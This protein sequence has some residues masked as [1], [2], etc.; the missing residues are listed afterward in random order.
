MSDGFLIETDGLRFAYREKKDKQ[1]LDGI[2]LRVKSN[3]YLLISGTSG[4]G[5]STL[6]R[7]FNGLIPHFTGG[8]LQGDVRVSGITTAHRTTEQLF[9]QVG[10]VFQN[11][12]AQ[13]FNR[14][15]ER[16]M[17]F[18]LESIGLPQQKMKNRIHATAEKI[19]ISTLMHRSPAELS[20]GEQQL[21]AI[22]AIMVLEPKLI[23]L[24]EPYSSLDPAHVGKV[25]N[26]LKKIHRQG[27]GIIICEHRLPY[28]VPDICRMLVLHDQKIVLDGSPQDVLKNH[29][30]QFGLELPLAARMGKH[31]KKDPLPLDIPALQKIDSLDTIPLDDFK[32]LRLPP[33][34]NKAEVVLEAENISFVRNKLHFLKDVG[35]T[36]R[37]GE[38][39]AVVGGNGAG[40]TTLLKHLI[41]LYRPTRGKVKVLG[42]DAGKL[43]VSELARYVGMAFQN[44]DNQFFRQTA[45]DEITTGAQTLGCYDEAWIK[46]LVQ[47]FNLEQLLRRAPYRLSGGE[48]KRVAFASAL[49]ANPAIL[50]LDEPT[51]GQDWFF[52]KTLGNLLNEMRERGLAIILVTHD[53]AFAEQYAHQWLVLAGGRVAAYDEPW[54]VMA[55]KSIL[56][57]AN[58][59]PTDAF[60]LFG[61]KY[62]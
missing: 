27:I 51:S 54:K 46:K 4:S 62:A 11:P 32:P 9:D 40:K 3:D 28:T 8:V 6:C 23:V 36:L 44:P 18:G 42:R 52:R 26:V 60:R 55:D 49:A 21:V 13:L 38:C 1:V 50:A 12:E 35:F 41:G 34:T 10:M 20:L 58:L 47:L 31:L 61:K 53:L 19:G 15:V 48:K 33:L 22:A 39:L 7:T 30:E 57:A 2:D 43:K 24:D 37:R 5:K 59:E 17:A 29:L 14:T 45:I 56:K 25:R 16:E